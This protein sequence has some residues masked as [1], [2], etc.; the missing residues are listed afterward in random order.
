MEKYG[1][2]SKIEEL[3]K[4]EGVAG[5]AVSVTDSDGVIFA[6]GFGTADVGSGRPV[7]PA[8]LFRIASITKIFTGLLIMRLAE[9]GRLSLDTPVKEYLD[10]LTLSDPRATE[11]VTL[12]HLLSHTSGLPKEYTPE[13]PLDEGLTEAMLREA[14]PTLPLESL[15]GDNRILY[16]NWGVRLASVVAERVMGERYSSLTKRYLIDPLGME[17]TFFFLTGS[18]RCD[19]SYPHTRTDDG[20]SVSYSIKENYTRLAAGGLYSDVL[21]LSRLAR[22]LIH[23]GVNDN[24]ERVISEASLCEMRREIATFPS[25]DHYGITHQMH[26]TPSGV[27]TFGHYGNADPYTSALFVARDYP[28]G[29]VVHLNTYHASLRRTI[30]ELVFDELC[31]TK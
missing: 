22:L 17:N 7:L 2:V 27:Y 26:L 1:F 30:C 10:W 11:S 18:R 4:S 6:S 12:R 23:G 9:E 19:L 5:A 24:G 25:G 3:L 29:V 8:S 31:H 16:S 14:L 28:L 21:D 15:P 20:F 13:G